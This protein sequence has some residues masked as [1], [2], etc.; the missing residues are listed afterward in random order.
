MAVWLR[1]AAPYRAGEIAQAVVPITG[2]EGWL[3]YLSKHASRGVAHYQRQGKPVGWT[4]TGRLW[5]K[6][7]SWPTGEPVK[8]DLEGLTF[9]RFRRMVRGY[10]VAEARSAALAARPGSDEARRA[11]QRVARLR[12]L[13]RINDRGRSAARGVG[14][15]LP[16]EAA[17][18]LALCAGWSGEV[19][20]VEPA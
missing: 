9:H 3:K 4:S 1:L 12:R 6:G 18:M 5:G 8:V 10:V 16:Q 2:A 14:E 7:G 13:L 15:W 20:G 11:W 17:L 19:R